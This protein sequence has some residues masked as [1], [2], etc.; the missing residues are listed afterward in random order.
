MKTPKTKDE[1]ESFIKFLTGTLIPDLKE[2]GRTST[3]EDFQTCVNIILMQNKKITGSKKIKKEKLSITNH[4]TYFL[5][6]YPINQMWC[7]AMYDYD[8][9]KFEPCLGMAG[10]PTHYMP[11]PIKPK[12]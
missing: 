6:F 2:S 7:M 3:A 1:L 8:K 9:N 5:C 11:L 10:N 12:S 4:R